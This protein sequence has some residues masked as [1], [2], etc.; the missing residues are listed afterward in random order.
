MTRKPTDQKSEIAAAGWAKAM[1]KVKKENT[2]AESMNVRLN[3]RTKFGLELLARHQH[4][5]LS[6]VVDWVLA[7][8]LRTEEMPSPKGDRTVHAVI[9]QTWDPHE[10]D[11]LVLL[12]LWDTALLTYEESLI[13]KTIQE[14]KTFWTAKKPASNTRA[15]LQSV[16]AGHNPYPD[17][18][19]IRQN[20]LQI[21]AAAIGEVVEYTE[22]R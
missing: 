19:R 15:V 22:T 7:E 21:R 6:S 1:A 18:A 5:S 3:P 9:A 17:F 16:V 13:W 20:W 10:A 4:R 11:R 2:K 12:A 14:E 8:T